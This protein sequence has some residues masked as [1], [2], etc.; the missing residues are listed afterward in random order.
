MEFLQKQALIL[1]QALLGVIS[2]NFRMVS[3]YESNKKII[4][5]IVL[6]E[7]LVDD[8]E[9]IDDFI[10]EFE[11]LQPFQTDFDIRVEASSA[12]INWPD[13]STIVVYRRKEN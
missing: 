5:N 7:Y 6:E 9:E 10:S 4:I 2:P 1:M 12:A 11:A 13:G 3:I 8:M